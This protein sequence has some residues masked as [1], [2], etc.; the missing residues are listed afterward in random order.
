MNNLSGIKIISLDF[1]RTLVAVDDSYEF[2]WRNFLGEN[3]TNEKGLR[4][5]NRATETLSD[6]FNRASVSDEFKN[7]RSLFEGTYT[8]LF[9]E[10]ELEYDPKIAADF[11]V[12]GHQKQS[13]YKDVKPFFERI[14]GKYEVCL[15]TDAD[16]ELLENIRQIYNFDEVF[17]SEALGAYKLNP[18][19]FRRVLSH[20]KCPPEQILH[21][22]D[23]HTDIVQ[24]KRLGIQTCWINRYNQKWKYDIKP[25]YEV[26]SLLEIADLLG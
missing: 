26:K 4:Y 12:Q 22:G 6:I 20:Y 7:V 8:T 14:K 3:Y 16:I 9:A 1:F 15:S 13:L 21:I 18:K 2:V 17:V 23:S 24:P 25:D 10:M 5:W 19:F 11:L